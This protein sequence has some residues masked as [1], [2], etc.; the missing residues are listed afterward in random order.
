MYDPA[1]L[2]PGAALP[3][4]PGGELW[5]RLEGAPGEDPAAPGVCAL[6]SHSLSPCFLLF[7]DRGT[8]PGFAPSCVSWS[9]LWASVCTSVRGSP[10]V[11]SLFPASCSEKGRDTKGSSS[12]FNHHK[13]VI[14]SQRVFCPKRSRLSIFPGLGGSEHRCAVFLSFLTRWTARLQSRGHTARD[15][16]QRPRAG[17][18]LGRGLG[19][20]VDSHPSTPASGQGRGVLDT[21]SS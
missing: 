8:R 20:P 2:R 7:G 4:G 13:Q 19:L 10:R 12:L 9:R 5:G 15:A 1:G 3:A 14:F 17:F 18:T 11:S 6:A 21:P 16:L